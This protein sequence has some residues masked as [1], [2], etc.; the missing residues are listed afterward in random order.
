MA[1]DRRRTQLNTDTSAV[2]LP[3]VNEEVSHAILFRL[4]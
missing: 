2:I 4:R 3:N 1:G